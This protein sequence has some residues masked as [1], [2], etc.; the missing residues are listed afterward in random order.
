MKQAFIV[1][2]VL[3][4]LY[5][6]LDHTDPLPLDHE[7]IGLGANHMAHSLFGIV[8]FV[9]AGSVWWKGRKGRKQVSA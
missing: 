7:T 4:G 8:L 1:I 6:L 2:L 3:V 5:L 9:V